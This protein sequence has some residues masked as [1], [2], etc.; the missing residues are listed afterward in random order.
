M[1]RPTPNLFVIGAMRAGTTALHETLGS[2]PDIFMSAYK[3]PAFFAD[4]MELAADSKAAVAAGYA[5]NRDRYL[6]LF[7][8]GAEARYRGESST[9][10]S[11]APRI[12]GIP[13]RVAALAP[14]ARIIYLLRD[15]VERTLSH[16]RYAVRHKTERR[17]CLEALQSDDFYS[18]VSDYAYQIEPYLRQFGESRVLL[19]VLEE[20]VAEPR[21]QL[22]GLYE[23]LNVDPA[24]AQSTF[25]RR[26][27]MFDRVAVAHG[28][29][30][31][32]RIGAS[33]RYQRV[34][35]N[36]IPDAIRA[37][38]RGVLYRPLALDQVRTPA[39]LQFLAD[40]HGPQ[41]E[42]LEALTGRRFPDWLP[43]ESM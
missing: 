15:P 24:A 1:S 21:R 42:R 23:W 37:K 41:V 2:H 35:R 43:E 26:N 20:L 19:L 33:P 5:G 30:I 18:T 10:Y 17:P 14:D 22:V 36:V 7:R 8:E 29:Q 34:A 13:E 6:G 9:H 27:A 38:V 39:V 40:V 3:E 32:H 12:S 16:Y 4:A 11:K 25:E 28:P 31:F